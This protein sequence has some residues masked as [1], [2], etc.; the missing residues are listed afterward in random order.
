MSDNKNDKTVSLEDIH[1][2]MMS[3]LSSANYD[4]SKWEKT[5]DVYKQFSIYDTSKYE[6]ISSSSIILNKQ[7]NMPSWS[8]II[9]DVNLYSNAAV[10]LDKK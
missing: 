10:E 2:K 6:S 1:K 4:Y 8:E 5:R 7:R 9:T 3:T